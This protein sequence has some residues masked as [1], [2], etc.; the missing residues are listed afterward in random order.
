MIKISDAELEVMKII[1]EKGEVTSQEII[2]QLKDFNWNDNTIRTL[3]N[4]LISKKAVKVSCKQSKAY[5]Y[6]PLVK[7]DDYRDRRADNFLKQFFHG[8]MNEMLLNLVNR[9]KLTK[10]E[11]SF[12]KGQIDEKLK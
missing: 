6:V 4:R 2:N 12:L 7:E 8:S 3:L 9:N 1:W 11:L 10:D 5:I